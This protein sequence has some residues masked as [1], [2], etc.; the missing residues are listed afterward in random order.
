[1]ADVSG[2]LGRAKAAVRLDVRRAARHDADGSPAERAFI[3][4]GGCMPAARSTRNG[5][6]F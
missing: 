1:M 2:W 4:R 5:D 3:L 6:V